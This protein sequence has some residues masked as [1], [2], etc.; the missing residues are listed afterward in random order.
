MAF[1]PNLFLFA[2]S[3]QVM[4]SSQTLIFSPNGLSYQ[5]IKIESATLLFNQKNIG[6]AKIGRFGSYQV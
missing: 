3:F 2:R 5:I 6:L 4:I 1:F